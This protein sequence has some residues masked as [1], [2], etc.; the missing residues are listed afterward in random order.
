MWNPLKLEKFLGH[1][2]FSRWIFQNIEVLEAANPARGFGARRAVPMVRTAFSGSGCR[3]TRC[4]MGVWKSHGEIGC[5]L[6]HGFYDFPIILGVSSS[7]LTN[8]IIFQRG[9][10]TINQ[11]GTWWSKPWTSCFFVIF[12]INPLL[13][14]H[15]KIFLDRLDSFL[16]WSKTGAWSWPAASSDAN[17]TGRW[18]ECL[19]F[20]KNC[21]GSSTCR[22][23]SGKKW[24][25]FETPTNPLWEQT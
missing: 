2:K 16:R 8:S 4:V 14:K 11:L 21:V 15:S 6:E 23:H 17:F 7:Q 22:C 3:C 9:G 5:C 18:V 19:P 24:S 10:S 1:P 25:G 12:Q 13:G 20:S